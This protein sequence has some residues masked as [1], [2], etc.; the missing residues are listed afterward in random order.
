[1]LLI[2][3]AA[4]VRTITLD[5]PEALNAFNSDLYRALTAAL[6][7]AADDPRVA[8]VLITG[9]GRAFSA[10]NDL[11]EM[12]SSVGDSSITRAEDHPF[13]AMIDALADFPKP[14]LVA[15]NGLALGIGV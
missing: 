8:V 4:R 6:R 13:S 10:G 3:D 9:T 7:D 14:L 1:M 12:A 15:V 2:G 5:R 11:R